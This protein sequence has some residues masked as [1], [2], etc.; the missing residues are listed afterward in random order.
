MRTS[1][2]T[3]S[4]APAKKAAVFG[5]LGALALVLSLLDS[6]LTATLPVFP[7]GVKPGLSNI[8]ATVAAFISPAGGFFVLSIK[9]VFTLASR[10]MSAAAMSLSGGILAVSATTLLVLALKRS[11][12]VEKRL[13]YIGIC[14]LSAAL[15]SMGQLLCACAMSGTAQLLSY[16]KYLLLFSLIS[17]FLTGVVLN[18]IMPRLEAL[19]SNQFS[20]R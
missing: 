3:E 10:G 7:V 17:G 15:H 5:I 16:G 14:V 18:L 6:L 13:S 8:A 2:R 12:Y 19:L 20:K 1:S 9:V 4:L 11:K